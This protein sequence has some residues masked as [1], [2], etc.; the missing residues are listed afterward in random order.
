MADAARPPVVGIMARMA[1]R[2][3]S[4]MLAILTILTISP[5]AED[6]RGDEA[7][8][9]ATGQAPILNGDRVRARDRALDESFR[10][11]IDQ[12]IAALPE[13]PLPRAPGG[14][15]ALLQLRI[16]PKARSYIT[17]Y[18]VLDEG[19][20]GPGSFRI[21]IA[22]QVERERLQRDLGGTETAAAPTG[23]ARIGVCLAERAAATAP[24][25][26]GSPTSAAAGLI[27][28]VAGA[29]AAAGV[30]AVALPSG[31]SPD[32]GDDLAIE[33][34]AS[35][36]AHTGGLAGAVA[37]AIQIAPGGGIRGTSLVVARATV[38][39]RMVDA[40]G[41]PVAAALAEH[42]GWG[43]DRAAAALAAAG[44]ALDEATEQLASAAAQRW[45][46]GGGGIPVHVEGAQGWADVGALVQALAVLPGVGPVEL[47]RFSVGGVELLARGRADAAS[48][49]AGLARAGGR[50]TAIARG[51][52]LLVHVAAVPT[53]PTA[54]APTA[55]PSPRPPPP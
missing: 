3:I 2:T 16:Y 17:T 29:L 50:F 30:D 34:R 26:R 28:R 4:T 55:Q 35:H 42:E 22:A 51:E 25:H 8:V 9:E 14:R 20:A 41:H 46:A 36:A 15:A 49:V 27:D 32:D 6:A 45:P 13:Q 10:Q 53:P 40:G 54:Q 18:R 12:A 47:R 48:L 19:E 39:L 52:S 5:L 43:A 33:S 44:A 31:C 37:G 11:A 1:I 23:G 24:G 21:R 7:T 38:R